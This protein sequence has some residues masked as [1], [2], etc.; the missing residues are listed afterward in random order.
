M[1]RARN[2]DD[3]VKQQSKAAGATGLT[4][5]LFEPGQSLADISKLVRT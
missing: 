3:A 1:T 5:K 2:H 4:M